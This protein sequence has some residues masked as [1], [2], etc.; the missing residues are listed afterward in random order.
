MKKNYIVG[1]IGVLAFLFLFVTLTFSIDEGVRGVV[2]R[3][4]EVNRVV[5]PGL[6]VRIP[7]VEGVKKFSVR[8]QKYEV[9]SASASSDLQ[10]VTTTVAVQYFVNPDTVSELFT[11]YGEYYRERIIHP[12]VQEVV[13]ASTAKYNATELITKRQEVKNDIVESLINRLSKVNI[14]VENIDIVDFSFSKSFTQSIEEKVKAEQEALKEKNRLEKVKFEA[15]QT[16]E[17]AQAEA[18]RIRLESQA[19]RD[20]P[21]IIEKMKIEAHIKA[22]EAWN[23]VLP[24]TMPPDTTL[25][26]LN[27]K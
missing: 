19:L 13:K 7:A 25:P 26:L 24:T 15:Q 4:G 14:S 2:V 12:A 27:I 10:N 3:F 22:I 9:E 21:E 6:H 5:D 17:Q 11:Q 8:T 16:V 18:K 1:I 20:S 23:G